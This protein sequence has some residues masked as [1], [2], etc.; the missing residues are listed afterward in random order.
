LAALVAGS[1]LRAGIGWGFAPLLDR[2]SWAA[3]AL[4]FFWYLRRE[5][6]RLQSVL[7]PVAAATAVS[8]AFGLTMLAATREAPVFF[9]N[10]NLAAQFLGFGLL[11][12]AFAPGLERR[13]AVVGRGLVGLAGGAYVGLL[14][15]RSVVLGLAAAALAHLALRRTPR[16]PVPVV[17]SVILAA[18]ALAVLA[19]ASLGARGG[20]KQ[21]SVTARLAVWQ[22][23]LELIRDR[24]LGVGAANFPYAF[25]PYQAR[26]PYPP[27]EEEIFLTPHNE[28]LRVLAEEGVPIAGAAAVLLALLLVQVRRRL[29]ER[30]EENVAFLVPMAVFLGVE[31]FFQFPLAVATG[32]SMAALLLGLALAAVEPDGGTQP[33]A[34]DA[35]APRASAWR[36]SASLAAAALLAGLGLV[37]AS[38][39]LSAIAGDD[40]QAHSRACR[41]NP[42]NLAACVTAAWLLAVSGD[43][44]GSRHAVEQVL[45]RAADYPPAVKL[46]GELALQEGRVAEGCRI[47]S[48]YDALYGGRS[49]V[50]ETLRRY[51]PAEPR[52]GP[53]GSP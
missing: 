24:P 38:E 41:F 7:A 12:L 43:T 45:G 16:R 47:L 53:D 10:P 28:Y 31:S 20:L 17:S 8:T 52:R 15:T 27:R 33:P 19:L 25:L 51:C 46:R 5:G 48:R 39:H 49:S 21:E 1:T 23:T 50:Q 3:L 13:A 37:V 4:C 30:R 2:L 32:A 36:V 44:A 35:R 40:L 22:G 11:F 18:L 34:P 9:G 14:G 42:R 26:G 29:V 6:L